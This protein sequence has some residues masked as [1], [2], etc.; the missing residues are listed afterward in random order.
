MVN[1][2]DEKEIQKISFE[3]DLTL[4]T[5]SEI[6]DEVKKKVTFEK[7]IEIIVQ[8]ITNFDVSAIQL[9]YALKK[10]ALNNNMDI[11]F[12]IDLPDDI[13]VLL[14]NAGFTDIEMKEDLNIDISV[15]D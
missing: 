15:E 5:I 9:L 11:A 3:G 6:V 8:K 4:N 10:G 14:Q 1:I 13:K 7:N 12:N 2:V